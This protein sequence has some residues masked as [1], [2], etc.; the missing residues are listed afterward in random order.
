MKLTLK[1]LPY[2][3]TTIIVIVVWKIFTLTDNYAW[4]PKGKD[5]LAL[6]IAL[7]FI[8]ITKVIFWIITANIF[9]FS[10]QNLLNKN[11]KI[12]LTFLLIGLLTY[13]FGEKWTD[14]KVAMNYYTVFLKQSVSEEYIEEPILD[15][16]YEIGKYLAEDIYDK[17]MKYR[18]YAIAGIGKIR[19]DKANEVLEKILFDP[20][21]NEII[22]NDVLEALEKIGNYD[23]KRIISNFKFETNNFNYRK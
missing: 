9:V 12:G 15:A 14:K 5:V 3:L 7:Y 21:E 2:I 11:Y 8:F 17:H 13:F 16:G 4:N 22:K 1:I 20:S 10:I 19:Y 6:D 23:A 18:R